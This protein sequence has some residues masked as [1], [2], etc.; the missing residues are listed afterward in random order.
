VALALVRID[1]RLLHGQVA[2]GW[3]RA[4]G[5]KL[6]V[7]ANDEVA[8]DGFLRR[9]YAEAA[10]P[11]V[12]VRI[13]T[14]KDTA[15]QARAVAEGP[16]A[17][18]IVVKDPRDLLDLFEMGAPFK[19]INIGGMHYEEGRLELLPYVYVGDHDVHSLRR[20][21]DMGLVVV[22]QDVPGNERHDVRLLLDKTE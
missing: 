15:D 21:L 20:L 22:A 13:W 1:D 5:S 9:L 16:D 19:E 2:I 7:V 11:G 18:I 4:L 8:G 10:P 6:I 17:A 12:R 14:L 3:A